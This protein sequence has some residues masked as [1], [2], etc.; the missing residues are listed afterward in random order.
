[1]RINGEVKIAGHKVSLYGGLRGWVARFYSRNH[2]MTIMV[3]GG[4][5]KRVKFWRCSQRETLSGKMIFRGWNGKRRG[6]R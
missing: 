3:E 2:Y 5:G 4:I 1:M 6:A